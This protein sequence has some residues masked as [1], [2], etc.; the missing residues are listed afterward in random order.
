LIYKNPKK[1][2]ELNLFYANNLK[3]NSSSSSSSK[4]HEIISFQFIQHLLVLGTLW[5][6]EVFFKVFP[7]DYRHYY[8]PWENG[9]NFSG[10]EFAEMELFA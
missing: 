1:F 2:Q 3:L 5:H 10:K 8:L 9:N 6:S 4:K 7:N